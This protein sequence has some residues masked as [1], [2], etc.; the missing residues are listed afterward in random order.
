MWGKGERLLLEENIY[1]YGEDGINECE[2]SHASM[3]IGEGF[4]TIRIFEDDWM[5]CLGGDDC[6]TFCMGKRRGSRREI[7]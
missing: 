6:G 7:K 3:N 5:D 1:T 2:L 4:S